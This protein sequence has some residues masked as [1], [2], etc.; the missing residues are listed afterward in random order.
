MVKPRTMTRSLLWVDVSSLP[1]APNRKRGRCEL[2]PLGDCALVTVMSVPRPY[3]D[4]RTLSW[5]FPMPL[6]T[7]LTTMT[8]AMP[9][10]RQDRKS[11]V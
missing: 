11:V 5:A 9:G 3:S 2:L 1:R 7:E 4:C 10:A 6:D 8:S